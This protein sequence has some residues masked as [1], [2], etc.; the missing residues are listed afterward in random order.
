MKKLLIP[1]LVIL[2]LCSGC[3]KADTSKKEVTQVAYANMHKRSSVGTDGALSFENGLIR[4]QDTPSQKDEKGIPLCTKANCKHSSKS[5]CTACY[6]DS[7][8]LAFYFE[9]K[10]F[11]IAN[12]DIKKSSLYIAE[13]DGTHQKKLFDL[14]VQVSAASTVIA[15]DGQ[16]YALM[17]STHAD[18]KTGEIERYPTIVKID[19]R[20]KQVDSIAEPKKDYQCSLELQHV[21]SENVYYTYSYWDYKKEVVDQL[22]H[23]DSK[24]IDKLSDRY[25]H[26]TTYKYNIHSKKNT[27]TNQLEK[28]SKLFVL[29]QDND[30]IYLCDENYNLI[31]RNHASG[32]DNII[33]KAPKGADIFFNKILGM[34]YLICERKNKSFVYHKISC[35]NGKEQIW[36][37]NKFADY[38]YQLNNKL[39][40]S[41]WD[42][43]GNYVMVR[44]TRKS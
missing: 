35:L 12:Q 24:T 25:F 42:K 23:A 9:S 41:Y 6:P 38:T 44:E 36:K 16:I 32:K 5:E 28:P 3:D 8:F 15:R 33:W 40:K 27:V 22:R 4:Y 31:A 39:F 43:E 17:D 34:D 37:E 29:T 14:D 13:L 26:L 20:N 11:V 18:E 7:S 10:L 30:N 1:I 21:D 19:Y 2:I